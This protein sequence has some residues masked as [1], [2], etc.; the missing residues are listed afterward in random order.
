M[1]I[2]QWR[3][4]NTQRIAPISTVSSNPSLTLT[5]AFDAAGVD[6]VAPVPSGSRS[7][8]RD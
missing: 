2:A 8:A 4:C 6:L 1:R 5:V 7:G 3:P